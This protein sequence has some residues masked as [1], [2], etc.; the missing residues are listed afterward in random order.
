MPAGALV[1]VPDPL[2]LTPRV[3]RGVNVAL[4]VCAPVII[5]V[6]LDPFVD[7]HAPPQAVKTLPCDGVAVS[8]TVVPPVNAAAHADGQST[9]AGALAT[10]PAPVTF[11][12]RASKGVNVAVTLC[13]AVMDTA[14][15]GPALDW[16]APPQ[17]EKTLPCDALAVRATVVPLGKSARHTDPHEMPAGALVTVPEP[18][19]LTW[20]PNTRVKLA[21]TVCAAVIDS[22]HVGPLLDSQSPVQP[23][24]VLPSA[25]VAVSVTLVPSAKS[26]LHVAPQATPAGTL[27]I[28][29]SPL[30]DRATARARAGG[31]GGPPRTGRGVAVGVLVGV[32]VARATVGAGV[33]VAVAVV[34]GVT[35]GVLV[36]VASGVLV[37]VASGVLVDVAV[38]VAGSVAVAVGSAG[39]A[40]VASGSRSTLPT[41]AG[42]TVGVAG[43]GDGS[44]V[45]GSPGGA[46]GN[47]VGVGSGGSTV[48]SGTAVGSSVGVGMTTVAVATRTVGVDAGVAVGTTIVAVG[49]AIGPAPSGGTSGGGPLTTGSATSGLAFTRI[50]NG[51]PEARSVASNQAVLEGVTPVRAGAPLVSRLIA[52]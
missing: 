35:S 29:P 10:L 28:V 25:T 24:N 43:G 21:P 32:S 4:M 6:Q 39:G 41:R 11:T 26:A 2:A 19:A 20:S 31:G 3:Y 40:T 15:V 9:P 5:T 12:W 49:V 48:C 45:A 14:Q 30:P 13:A 7:A 42:A 47:E 23:L 36:G 37:G 17:R 18:L 16:H 8:T 33:A 38:G 1:T 44:A 52:C 50:V 27:V 51:S 34:V 22:V 46:S